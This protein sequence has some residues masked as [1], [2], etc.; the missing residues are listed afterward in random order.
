MNEFE[1]QELKQ[2]GIE[3]VADVIAIAK[4]AQEQK[5]NTDKVESEVLTA[6]KGL[7]TDINELKN[8]RRNEEEAISMAE[9]EKSS[10]KKAFGEAKTDEER[11]AIV[12]KAMS[13]MGEG[14]GYA[15]LKDGMRKAM[16]APIGKNAP[17]AEVLKAARRAHDAVLTL[18]AINGGIVKG[19]AGNSDIAKINMDEYHSSIK[20]L[21]RYEFEGID[22]YKDV[23]KA[24]GDAFDT[25]TALDGLEWLPTNM[26]REYVDAIY[27]PLQAAALIKR[28]Q[29]TA[30]TFVMPR[31]KGR[32]RASNM[33]ESLVASDLYTQK[34]NPSMQSSASITFTAQ[35]LGVTQLYSSEVDQDAIV[36]LVE[37]IMG[38]ISDGIGA[39]IEDS[40][41]NGS[42]DLTTLDNAA[43]SKLYTTAATALGRDMFKGFRNAILGTNGTSIKIDGGT[44]ATGLLR[45]TR[46]QMG[47]YGADP[48]KLFWIVS[49][50]N[51]MNVLGLAEVI[52][53]DKY[54]PN[55]TILT[56]E[57]GKI[58][59]IPIIVSEFAYINLNASGVY[60]NVTTTKNTMVLV[61]SDAWRIG[62]R[63]LVRI[64]SD[65]FITSDQSVV[66]G[67]WRGDIQKIQGV[68]GATGQE[69]TEGLIYNIANL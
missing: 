55:A 29:M 33:A 22:T 9:A 48:R 36:P 20:T 16:T 18:T 13:D 54:G 4:K 42:G 32:A 24:A 40:L 2:Y 11:E 15:F 45:K 47:R 7:T 3:N 1:L 38:S 57:I 39:S 12:E 26:S 60:D 66:V 58:D 37:M 41:I 5:L 63:R 31:V 65:T 52:T 53:V 23:V 10:L 67:S 8:D 14:A 35:K 51:L 34:A 43:A 44:F 30:K 69:T 59:G 61:Y 25:A 68:N 21:D 50:N 49:V 27:L 19:G 6:L 64:Q 28:I 56:G 46:A 62:D 17:D